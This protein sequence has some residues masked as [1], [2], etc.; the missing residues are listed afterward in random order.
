MEN[1]RTVLNRT[2]KTEKLHWHIEHWR[3]DL[4]FMEDETRFLEQLLHSDV[5]EPDTPHLS[6]RI[7]KYSARLDKFK[8]RK[9]RL[10]DLIAKHERFLGSVMASQ[11]EEVV[12]DFYFRHD[13]LEMEVLDC[14]DDFKSLKK[15]LFDFM[16]EALRKPRTEMA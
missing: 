5:F 13:D 2:Q 3:S 6:D 10:R 16:A 15:E 7:Q 4:Q 14:T 12:S 8:A 1:T 9:S 11:D